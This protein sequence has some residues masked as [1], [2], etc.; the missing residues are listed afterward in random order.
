MGSV[1]RMGTNLELRVQKAQ[2]AKVPAPPSA[3]TFMRLRMTPMIAL[4][5]GMRFNA[6]DGGSWGEVEAGKAW[7]REL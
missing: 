5:G 4:Q 1:G 7:A 6:N 3:V 2:P